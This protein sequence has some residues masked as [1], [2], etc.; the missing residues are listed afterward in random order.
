MLSRYFCNNCTHRDVC[1]KKEIYSC[2][3]DKFKQLSDEYLDIVDIEVKC[4][5]YKSVNQTFLVQ[6]TRST[7]PN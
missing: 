1:S 4:R 3:I 5:Y 2:Y 7:D 6:G